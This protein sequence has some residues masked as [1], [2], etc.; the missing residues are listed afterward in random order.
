MTTRLNITEMELN[1]SDV[2]AEYADYHD[3]DVD[4]CTKWIQDH[5]SSDSNHFIPQHLEVEWLE[6]CIGK[7]R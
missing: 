4:N 5:N 2:D 1:I 7:Q 3:Y 6:N